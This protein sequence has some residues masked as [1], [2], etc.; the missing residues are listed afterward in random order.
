MESAQGTIEPDLWI[1]ARDPS[2]G[3]WWVVALR[4]LGSVRISGPHH[5]HWRAELVLDGRH[6]PKSIP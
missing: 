5:S 6:Q 4:P 1:I 3:T 2:D